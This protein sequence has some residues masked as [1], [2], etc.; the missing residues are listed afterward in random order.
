MY[1]DFSAEVVKSR[2]KSASACR[3]LQEAGIKYAFGYPAVNNISH[4]NGKTSSLS[5]TEEIN[6][7]IKR[8]PASQ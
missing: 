7:Y 4:P 1:Q 8:L 6:D 5:N 2:K 3:Q